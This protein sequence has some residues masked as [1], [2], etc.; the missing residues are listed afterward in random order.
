MQPAQPVLGYNL[1][2]PPQVVYYYQTNSQSAL[3][4]FHQFQRPT[5]PGFCEGIQRVPR[6][7]RCLPL[8]HMSP[9]LV[10]SIPLCEVSLESCPVPVK[11]D[12]LM[13]CTDLS[14]AAEQIWAEQL[15]RLPC[16]VVS[17][18]FLFLVEQS[19]KQ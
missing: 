7:K 16:L 13:S 12:S 10:V 9:P 18:K 6:G 14:K 4:G 1:P 15:A 8:C 19:T 17:L 3:V 11:E 5:R 2:P